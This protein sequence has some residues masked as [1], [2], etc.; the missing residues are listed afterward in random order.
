MQ[1]AKWVAT[2]VLVGGAV[3]V[4]MSLFFVLLGAIVHRGVSP[5]VVLPVGLVVFVLLGALLTWA[6]DIDLDD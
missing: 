2:G 1:K 4:P 6:F 5:W 3:V